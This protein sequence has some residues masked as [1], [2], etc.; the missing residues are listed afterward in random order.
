MATADSPAGPEGRQYCAIAE[1]AAGSGAGGG[2]ASAGG[3]GVD[4]GQGV[5]D[6]G[7]RRA[8]VGVIGCDC[9]TVLMLHQSKSRQAC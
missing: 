6:I 2:V 4:P 1:N 7:A 8:H 5:Y 9:A 3:A